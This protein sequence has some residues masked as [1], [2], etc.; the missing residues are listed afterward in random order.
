M[1][2]SKSTNL[3]LELTT[4]QQTLFRDWYKIMSGKGPIK[5]ADGNTLVAKSNLELIDDAVG[6]L[7]KDLLNYYTKTETDS[8]ISEAVK[9]LT[10]FDIK[11]VDS[12]DKVTE[13]GHLYLVP[14]DATDKTKGYY[15]YV[16]VESD[17]KAE[18]I[19][20]TDIVFD[21][22][23][24]STSTNGVQ[25]RVVANAINN[26]NNSIDD[27]ADVAFSGEYVDI[28]N[29]PSFKTIN[30]EEITGEGEINT[31]GGVLIVD[32]LPDDP[33]ADKLYKLSDDGSLWTLVD[34][35]LEQLA[36]MSE[37]DR[38]AEQNSYLKILVNSVLQAHD[39]AT[40]DAE[41]DGTVY[42]EVITGELP[43]GSIVPLE[44]ETN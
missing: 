20:S 15:E 38:L 42:K 5:D 23:L 32:T 8:A 31:G 44:Y 43:D 40:P 25:N 12:V 41:I 11:V 9:G 4:D 1:A 36:P 26:I 34:D 2:N 16:Y 18:L 22:Q 13:T 33:E 24:D 17:K 19:G 39:M 37:V 29:A 30:G 3:N 27:L 7:M 35:E 21:D 28:I 6:K 10:K 14:K